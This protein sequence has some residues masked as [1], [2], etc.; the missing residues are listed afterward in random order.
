MVFQS[1][2]VRRPE[3][4]ISR[5]PLIELG[6]WLGPDPVEAALGVRTRLDNSSL[7][8]H[9]KVLGHGRLA[10]AKTIDK[11]P[12]GSLPIPE[13]VEDGL[14]AGLAQRLEGSEG[15]HRVFQY[16]ITAI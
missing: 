2:Q 6:Q 7:L 16:T 11:L 12:D 14:P 5:Q 10:Q 13:K 15:R 3:L 8:E 9:P 1:I 4:A